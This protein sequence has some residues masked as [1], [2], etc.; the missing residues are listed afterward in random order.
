MKINSLGIK[1]DM[2]FHGYSAV[3]KDHGNF[4]SIKTPSNPGFRWGNYLLFENP[5]KRADFAIWKACFQKHIG[6]AP[7]VTHMLFAWDSPSPG[8]YS[9]FSKAGF[10]LEE[11]VVQTAKKLVKPKAAKV[12]LIMRPLDFKKE[13]PQVI[14]N[15][16]LTRGDEEAASYRAF[17]EQ[18]AK[19]YLKMIEDGAGLWFGAFV[20][21]KL[22]SDMGLFY[23]DKVARYQAVISLEK[24]RNLGIASNLVYFV[25]QFGF[26][27][28]GVSDL[29]IVADQNYHAKDIYRRLGFSG[30]EQNFALERH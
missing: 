10:T 8:E 1:T 22:V 7:E 2:I 23:Q 13:F 9:E 29:V 11:D 5:P 19:L 3:I 14:E 16:F 24:Y 12:E 6:T 27:N 25:G 4:K 26:N 21:G 15:H 18:N 17:W 20:E 30:N 28:F